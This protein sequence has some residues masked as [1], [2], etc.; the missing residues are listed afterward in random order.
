MFDFQVEA[1]NDN[2]VVAKV[3]DKHS[4]FWKFVADPNEPLRV[5]HDL[6]Q[7]K[8][9]N[10]KSKA[11]EF[12]YDNSLDDRGFKAVELDVETNGT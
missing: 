7:A 6:T 9:W 1:E 3:K 5:T 8:K 4:F 10:N 2:K 11:R 12:I